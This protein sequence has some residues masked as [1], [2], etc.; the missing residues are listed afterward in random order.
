MMPQ[1]LTVRVQRAH[2]RPVRIWVPVLPVLLVLSPFVLLAAVIAAVA[3]LVY[4]I[5]LLRAFG[6]VFCDATHR[7]V[8]FGESEAALRCGACRGT[9]KGRLIACCAAMSDLPSADPLHG[10]T[11]KVVV[12]RLV[13]HYGFPALGELNRRYAEWGFE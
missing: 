8:C 1:L 9:G 7:T 10:V 12:E 5:S 6:T 13:A 2:G 11:L 4:R 3:C